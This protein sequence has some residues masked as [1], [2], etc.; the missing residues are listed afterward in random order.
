MAPDA[1]ERI[2]SLAERLGPIISTV[3]TKDSTL[4]RNKG[5]LVSYFLERFL[6]RI[7][8]SAR[9]FAVNSPCSHGRNPTAVDSHFCLLPFYFLLS[10]RAAP[11]LCGELREPVE[12]VASRI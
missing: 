7:A 2:P 6:D 10:P 8:F 4:T 1:R 9:A 5:L 11:C 3:H 12:L